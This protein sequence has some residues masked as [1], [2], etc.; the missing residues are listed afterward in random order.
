[1]IFYMLT[2]SVPDILLILFE[3]Q[4]FLLNK[5]A[6]QRRFHLCK[7]EQGLGSI[8]CLVTNESEKTEQHC[9]CFK[10]IFLLLDETITNN[11]LPSS[12]KGGLSLKKR[13]LVQMLK[14]ICIE[15][16]NEKLFIGGNFKGYISTSI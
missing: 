16:S 2:S 7:R 10:N 14:K 1:M 12:C 5:R 9:K 8:H 3:I 6:D 13:R 11:F 15:G 4:N